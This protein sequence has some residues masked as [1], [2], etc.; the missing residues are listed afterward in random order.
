MNEEQEHREP[1]LLSLAEAAHR[2]GI[3]RSTLW[4][5]TKRQDLP[6]VR[7]GARALIPRT[8]LE[9]FLSELKSP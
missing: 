6:V 3:S 7:I 1:D 8:A 9:R 2:L 5:M 4:R